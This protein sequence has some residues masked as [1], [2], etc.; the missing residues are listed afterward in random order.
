MSAMQ[1]GGAATK[2]NVGMRGMYIT[3]ITSIS[4][5]I[6]IMKCTRNIGILITLN[7]TQ[8]PQRQSHIQFWTANLRDLYK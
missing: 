2:E 7:E 3:G 6:K 8:L 5:I 4:S 1:R